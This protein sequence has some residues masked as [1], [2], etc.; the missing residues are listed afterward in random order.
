MTSPRTALVTGATGQDGSY[1]CERL[2]A[3]GTVVHAL[4]HAESAGQALAALPWADGVAWHEG[5]LAD[6]DGLRDVVSAVVP[7]EI[8]NLG[9]ISSVA[10]SW[11]E[12]V[13]TAS[14]T[15]LGA[16]GLYDAAWRLQ[17]ETG[18]AVRVVQASSA[19][20]FG[21]PEVTPQDERT[22]VRP[23]SPYGAAKAF[24]HH[25]AAAYRERGLGVST[26]I[27]YNH[28]SPRRP[29]TFVTRKIARGAAAIAC[30]LADELA[31]GNLDAGRDWGWAPDYVDALVRANRAEAADD[32][33]VATGVA[34]TVRDFVRAAFAAAG[35]T[36]WERHLRVD[37]A[38]LRPA[39]PALLIGDASKARSILGWSPTRG[40]EQ[41]VAAMV[42]ADLATLSAGR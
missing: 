16:A 15:G 2:L 5:D 41:I 24:A 3:E 23:V 20:I 28:E 4:H 19:E 14:V 10:L 21:S 6:S 29:E 42:E 35:I 36:D 34:H 7:D 30:G 9:G 33:V 1:L 26:C 27:L 32:F 12:P 38:F 18:R 31:L 40:F 8:Y 13:L 11:Q 39:D 25:L 17:Q 37:P 22:P